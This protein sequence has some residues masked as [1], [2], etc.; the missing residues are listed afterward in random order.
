MRMFKFLD[1]YEEEDMKTKTKSSYWPEL[2][3]ML[4]ASDWWSEKLVFM[5]QYVQNEDFA[6]TDEY[7]ISNYISSVNGNDTIENNSNSSVAKKILFD[8]LVCFV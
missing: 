8:A 5:W 6:F 3:K 4:K 7:L 1:N 2:V